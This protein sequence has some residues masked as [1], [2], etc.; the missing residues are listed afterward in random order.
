[1]TA[2]R[3]LL[4]CLVSSLLINWLRAGWTFH[5]VQVLPLL[6]GHEPGIYD[7]VGAALIFVTLCVLVR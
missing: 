7:A 2:F 4:I 3:I 1:M 6:G 5:I